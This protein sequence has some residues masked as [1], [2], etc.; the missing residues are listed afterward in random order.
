MLTESNWNSAIYAHNG[1]KAIISTGHDFTYSSEI[2]YYASV[3]DENH[4]D[5]FQRSFEKLSDACR[6]LNN[7]YSLIW[8][9]KP[10]NPKKTGGCDSCVAH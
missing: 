2:L 10:L 3:M 8:E 6:Y 7:K 4:N 1:L 5:I 9:F